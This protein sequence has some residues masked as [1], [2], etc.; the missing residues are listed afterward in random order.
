MARKPRGFFKASAWELED[1]EEENVEIV[2]NHAPKAL[3][4][5]N[6]KLTGMVFEQLEYELDG[7]RASPPSASSARSCCPA[8]T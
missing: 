1:A 4:L 5:E 3:R 2:V 8:T 6:G 7:R